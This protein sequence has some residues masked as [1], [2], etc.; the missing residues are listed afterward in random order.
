MTGGIRR[1]GLRAVRVPVHGGVDAGGLQPSL[2]VLAVLLGEGGEG[3]EIRWRWSVGVVVAV[4][5]V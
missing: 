2:F 3:K 4:V 1:G 5:D